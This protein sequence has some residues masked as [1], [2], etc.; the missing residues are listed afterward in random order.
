MKEYEESFDPSSYR[1]KEQEEEQ[2]GSSIPAALPET[3]ITAEFITITR[4][5]KTMGFR[6]QIF[7]TTSLEDAE[8]RMDDYQEL[9]GD[10]VAVNLVFDAPYYKVRVGNHLD[11]ASADENCKQIKEIGLQE[12][13]V[14]RD[15]VDKFINE[16]VQKR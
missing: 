4:I 5:E 12:A 7:S 2:Q 13:W 9:L 16:K 1:D 14:V 10:T 6:V 3:E 11:K 8:R 15:R